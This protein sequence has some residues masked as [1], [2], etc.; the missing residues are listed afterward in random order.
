MKLY[1]GKVIDEPNEKVM[2]ELILIDGETPRIYQK[3]EFSWNKCGIGIFAVEKNS[4]KEV[5]IYV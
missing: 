2:G 4:I 1:M 5:T 3:Q